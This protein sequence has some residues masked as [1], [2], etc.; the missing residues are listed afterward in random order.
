MSEPIA[1]LEKIANKSKSNKGKNN[2]VPK[3][4]KK[5]LKILMVT[6]LFYFLNIM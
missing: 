2:V 6:F 3:A 1:D 4:E 5:L